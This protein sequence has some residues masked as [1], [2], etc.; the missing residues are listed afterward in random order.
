MSCGRPYVANFNRRT[1]ADDWEIIGT[2]MRQNQEFTGVPDAYAYVSMVGEIATYG[3]LLG[4]IIAAMI[5]QYEYDCIRNP[6]HHPISAR[7][8]TV[9]YLRH[10][11]C[12]WP[13]LM[14]TRHGRPA[15]TMS[16]LDH[17]ERM[18][19]K[20]WI[21]RSMSTSLKNFQPSLEI[22]WITRV[23]D[24]ASISTAQRIKINRATRRPP[25]CTLDR[26]AT[27][28]YYLPTKNRRNLTWKILFPTFDTSKLMFPIQTS[29][30]R[31]T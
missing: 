30:E 18:R 26:L 16:M 2:T 13:L 7:D 11:T 21:R 9:I 24:C 17:W 8:C 14:A 10:S 22:E 28:N 6:F 25:E 15:C 3:N 5:I 23:S 12:G 29:Y 20:S 19:E 4:I 27:A 31:L 1:K